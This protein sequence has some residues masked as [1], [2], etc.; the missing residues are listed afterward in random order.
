[1]TS[2]TASCWTN[3]AR[4]TGRTGDRPLGRGEARRRAAGLERTSGGRELRAR[5]W[6]ARRGEKDDGF[7]IAVSKTVAVPVQRL[8]DAFVDESQRLKAYRRQ[9]VAPIKEVLERE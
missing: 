7:A 8:Y 9:R 1:V 3:G 5:P 2:D 4:A 6:S